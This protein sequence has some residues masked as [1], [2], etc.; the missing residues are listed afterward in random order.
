MINCISLK[1]VV[2]RW[3]DIESFHAIVFSHIIIFS[4]GMYM[5]WWN[6]SLSASIS[7]QLKPILIYDNWCCSAVPHYS[8]PLYSIH[9]RTQY[10][11]DA[12]KGQVIRYLGG[13]FF[14]NKIY[15]TSCCLKKNNILKTSFPILLE[16]LK[17]ILG[18]T[19]NNPTKNNSPPPHPK[20]SDDQ[21]NDWGLD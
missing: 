11:P 17:H 6:N 15:L 21:P 20:I 9:G 1:L 2:T 10:T 14:F 3:H 5:L 19:I 16:N 7:D 4:Q 18:P 12:G 8:L 13:M